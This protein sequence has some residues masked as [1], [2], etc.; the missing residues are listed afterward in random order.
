MHQFFCL[1]PT[2]G[3]VVGQRLGWVLVKCSVQ[4]V[5]FSL[6]HLHSTETPEFCDEPDTVGSARVSMTAA[7]RELDD[8]E[9]E[10]DD[11]A[12]AAPA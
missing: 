9:E 3:G 1:G 12:T 8:G 2:E 4:E 7:V 10:D 11:E 6:C 5:H